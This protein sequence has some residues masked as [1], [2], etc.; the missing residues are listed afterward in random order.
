ALD[1]PVGRPLG[2]DGEVAEVGAAEGAAW[3]AW[4]AMGHAPARTP[5]ASRWVEPDA[6]RAEATAEAFARYRPLGL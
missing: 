3:L 2:P 4:S 5:R 1:A 6:A